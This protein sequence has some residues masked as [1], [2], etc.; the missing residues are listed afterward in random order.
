V[1]RPDGSDVR[2]LLDDP[3]A[4]DSYPSWVP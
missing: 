4:K 2:R 3:A 1:V